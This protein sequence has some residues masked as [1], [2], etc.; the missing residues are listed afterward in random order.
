MLPKIIIR[1][2]HNV[3]Q[4][5]SE[6]F[7]FSVKHPWSARDVSWEADV[8][9]TFRLLWRHGENKWRPIEVEVARWRQFRFRPPSWMTQFPFPVG[10]FPVVTPGSDPTENGNG[11]IQDG[12]RKRNCRHLATS[13]SMGR[14]L[15]SQ[16]YLQATSALPSGV[17][18][19]STE[20]GMAKIELPVPS[21]VVPAQLSLIKPTVEDIH[22]SYSLF[23]LPDNKQLFDGS[24][25]C[26]H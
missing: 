21:P 7:G 18:Q 17:G 19:C 6:K 3:F 9:R 20:R 22:S 23:Y 5:V 8:C 14:H 10:S 15:F 24:S 25:W 2:N 12:G 4:N 11:V 1:H 16:N 13:T 26:P